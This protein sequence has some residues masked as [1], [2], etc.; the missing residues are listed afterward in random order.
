MR[1]LV[2]LFYL[3]IAIISLKAQNPKIEKLWKELNKGNIDHVINEG[4][5][6]LTKDASN[7]ELNNLIGRAY[8]GKSDYET[9]IPY[10]ERSTQTNDPNS[11]TKAWGYNYLGRCYLAMND[12]KKAKSYFNKAYD[13]KA[14]KNVTNSS[15]KYLV[16]NGL[17][18]YFDDW[19]NIETDNFLFQFK[20]T[21][22]IDEFIKTRE[23]TFD[24]ISHYLNV[25]LDRK[26]IYIVWSSRQEAKEFL[27]LNIGFAIPS[28]Y[29]IHSASNQT[30]GHEMTHVISNYI[31]NITFKTG[32][33]NEGLAVHLD[34]ADKDDK[35][36]VL[37]AMK[38]YNINKISIK[39][40][41]DNWQKYSEDI[42][43]PLA[44]L[45]VGETIERY[46]K[47]KFLEF[48]VDQSYKNAKTV[49]GKDFEDFIEI[50]E[51]KFN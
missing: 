38:K 3:F 22:G 41:W 2:L 24:S 12:I 26:I 30:P 18:H 5:L 33:I 11:F 9:A 4:L 8:F 29:I 43:Y 45:F 16:R 27:N 44:G 28:E 23:R 50:F 7:I 17:H 32:L 46:G 48:F 20:D 42:S 39:S 10:L 35:N 37:A 21:V 40:F 31:N 36:N 51:A 15:Y 13:M 49:F 6:L 14:T 47:D 34:M 25:K 1:K 19:I